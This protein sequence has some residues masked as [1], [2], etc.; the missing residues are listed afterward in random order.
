MKRTEDDNNFVPKNGNDGGLKTKI[1][2]KYRKQKTYIV[3]CPT[4]R[5][6]TGSFLTG[7]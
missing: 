2:R 3:M 4:P 1:T 7:T 5:T 6:T